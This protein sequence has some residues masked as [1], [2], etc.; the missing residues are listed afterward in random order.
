MKKNPMKTTENRPTPK[1]VM[2]EVADPITDDIIE[3]SKIF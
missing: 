3:T 2:N 1:L